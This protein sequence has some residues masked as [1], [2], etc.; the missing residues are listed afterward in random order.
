MLEKFATHVDR[1]NNVVS[2]IVKENLE[3]HDALEAGQELPKL[4]LQLPKGAAK[5]L[6]DHRPIELEGKQARLAIEAS[7]ES[8]KLMGWLTTNCSLVAVICG[9]MMMQSQMNRLAKEAG[10]E[11][12]LKAFWSANQTKAVEDAYKFL[13][14]T[15]NALIR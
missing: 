4:V 8:V 7:Q 10:L 9:S 5:V 3:E 13:G 14:I 11:Q 6:A 15:D 1:Q 2:W 12:K